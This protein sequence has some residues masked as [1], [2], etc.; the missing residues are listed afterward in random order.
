MMTDIQN[1]IDEANRIE[2][3]SNLSAKGH[4]CAAKRWARTNFWLGLI[5]TILASL[6]GA[7]A[8]F[9][10]YHGVPLVTIIAG[11]FSLFA[12]TLAAIITFINPNRKSSSHFNSGNNYNEL[13]NDARIFHRI[14]I[15]NLRENDAKEKLQLLNGRR[16]ELN[17]RSDQ[18][19]DWAFKK[20]RK[21]I[22][23][24]ES[25]YCVDD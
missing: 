21:G 3:D 10:G 1:I 24:G 19:P 18:I 13:R 6:A 4:F 17:K 12:G 14:V 9:S 11:L 25:T 15:N 7:S 20:A 8:I 16:N 2:E 5:S 22:E 23:E